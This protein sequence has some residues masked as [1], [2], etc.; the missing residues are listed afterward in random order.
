LN[1]KDG[2]WIFNQLAKR[3]LTEEEYTQYYSEFDKR[4]IEACGKAIRRNTRGD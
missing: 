1:S 4:G 3:V 2:Y